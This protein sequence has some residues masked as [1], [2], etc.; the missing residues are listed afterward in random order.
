VLRPLLTV[1]FAAAM[2]MSPSVAQALSVG[3][4]DVQEAM[5]AT[6]HWDQIQEYLGARKKK[7]E[8][9]L[10]AKEARLK[11][12]RVELDA[13]R[14]VSTAAATQKEDAAWM[15]EAEQLRREMLSAQQRI[16]QLEQRLVQEVF[17][18]LSAVVQEVATQSNYDFVFDAGPELD[19]NVVYFTEKTDLTQRVVEAYRERFK[20]QPL[21][22][23]GS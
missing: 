5:Q 13:K 10:E 4:V 21:K 1:A 12:R 2:T 23:P 6:A 8:S 22:L 19:L 17:A 16:T 9:Q 11:E 20:D 18:R 3:V 14:A 7:L 15:Q